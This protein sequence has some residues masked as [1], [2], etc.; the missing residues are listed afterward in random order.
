MYG[1]HRNGEIY[2][3]ARDR[4]PWLFRCSRSLQRAYMNGL[5][6][7]N[8]HDSLMPVVLKLYHEL[9]S[10]SVPVDQRTCT[11]AVSCTKQRQ[12]GNVYLIFFCSRVGIA[13]VSNYKTLSALERQE[14]LIIVKHL[15]NAMLQSNMLDAPSAGATIRALDAV[16]GCL[17][18]FVL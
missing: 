1:V 17:L 3:C 10:G 11:S 4:R 13:R 12:V 7:D 8:R 18:H 16:G 2:V 5:L 9:Q 6:D 14:R 15:F